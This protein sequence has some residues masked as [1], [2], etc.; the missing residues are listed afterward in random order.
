MSWFNSDGLLVKFGT[1]KTVANKGG[2][3]RN[4]GKLR[5]VELTINLASLTQAEVIQSD[6]VFIPAGARIVKTTVL[7]TV[8]AA[9]G[10]AIDVGLIKTDRAT[11]IDYDGILAAFI[12]ASMNTVG[13]LSVLQKDVT[14]PTGLAG[15]GALHS[16]PTTFVGYITAS[17]TDATAFTAGQIVITIE[18]FMP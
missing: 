6:Q 2:E 4:Y 8:A 9:T 15:T 3:Y 10:T 5:K 11:E 14:I 16:I 13:E 17:M 18:Y 1:E 12:T 7:T